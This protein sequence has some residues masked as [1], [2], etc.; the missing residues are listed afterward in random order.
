MAA[1]TI[2]SNCKKQP[3]GINADQGGS[4]RIKAD[5]GG[6]NTNADHQSRPPI[7]KSTIKGQITG[8]RR[9]GEWFP[10]AAPETPGEFAAVAMVAWRAPS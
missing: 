3:M 5:Q 6:W 10:T 9:Q 4:R 1:L 8:K 2:A 7:G